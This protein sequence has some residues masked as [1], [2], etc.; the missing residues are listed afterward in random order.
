MHLTTLDLTNYRNYASAHLT[1]DEGRYVLAGD[2]AQGKSN[3]CE[4]I[5]MLATMRSFRATNDRELVRWGADG[6]FARID[7]TVARVAGPIS[8][9]IVV[10]APPAEGDLIATT[11]ATIA[12][13]LPPPSLTVGRKRIRING[14]PKRALDCVGLVTVVLFEPADLDLVIGPPSGRRHFLDITLCQISRSYCRTLSQYQ[15]ILTQRAAL[16]KRIRDNQDDARS[17]AYWDTQLAQMAVPIIRERAGLIDRC[18][19]PAD[20]IARKLNGHGLLLVYHPSF[21]VDTS[22]PEA[23]IVTAFQEKLVA[24]R[25]REIAQ[26]VNLLGPHRDDLAFMDGPINLATYGSRGQQRVAALSLK[27][28]ELDA[29][30]TETGDEPILVL[31]DVLSELDPTRRNGLLE[32]IQTLQQV[33]LSTAEPTMLPAE[34]MR[35]AHVLKIQAGEII[36]T[37]SDK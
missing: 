36:P 19:P 10:S 3:L 5:R 31:D 24:I 30:E 15:K 20:E 32:H 23:D 1:L 4:A 37:S 25:R 18:T 11:D 7:A 34:F 26:G 8:I 16:L 2:N 9:D 27:L 35:Q 28:A 33:I 29:I 14:V 17:L 21:A 22:L 12:S 6:H 13:V